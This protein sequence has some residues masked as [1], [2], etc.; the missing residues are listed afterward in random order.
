MNTIIQ[1][2]ETLAKQAHFTKLT[3]SERIEQLL[4]LDLTEQQQ[5]ALINLDIAKFE[6]QCDFNT[7]IC[8]ILEEPDD[9]PDEE[10]DS[11]TK[12]QSVNQNLQQ[13]I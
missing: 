10:E 4:T 8:L 12:K 9:V 1:T 6:Q 2:L 11:P 7:I 3:I 13:V 5:Q